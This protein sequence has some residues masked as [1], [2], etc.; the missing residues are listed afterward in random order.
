MIL[1]IGGVLTAGS[2]AALVNTQALGGSAAADPALV[3]VASSMSTPQPLVVKVDPA[4]SSTAGTSDD[5]GKLS[6]STETAPSTT[7]PTLP[8]AS[9]HVFN[10][11]VSG[12]VTVNAAAGDLLSLVSATP[13]SGWQ[14]TS[15]GSTSVN[16]V[17]VA[18]RSSTAVVTFTAHLQNGEVTT[19][20][21]A[22]ALQ[23]A[24][25]TASTV[26]TG[27]DDGSSDDGGSDD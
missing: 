2:A 20:V 18:F 9:T 12:V 7:A 27:S 19:S 10:V 3:L 21:G 6:G 26:Q 4:A 17:Q 25:A 1:S 11:G 16:D 23:S 24:G 15:A 22:S 5:G 8:A 13:L 14:V